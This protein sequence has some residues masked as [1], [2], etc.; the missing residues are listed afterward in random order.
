M[1]IAKKL[2]QLVMMT[3][4]FMLLTGCGAKE[5]TGV[6][7]KETSTAETEVKTEAA[8]EPTTKA[9]VK[10]EYAK[11]ILTD[12]SFES[13]YIG[14][15]FTLPEG[16]IMATEEDMDA[17]IDFGGEVIYKDNASDLLD[18]AKANSVYEMMA[19]SADQTANV[20]V[21]VEK[22]PL[23]NMTVDQYIASVKTQLQ[24]TNLGYVIADE[25]TSFTVGGQEFTSLTTEVENSNVKMTQQYVVRKQD[26]RI[27]ALIFTTAEGVTDIH[28]QLVSAFAPY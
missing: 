7:G 8:T 17:M 10:K 27:I 3:C 4:V 1:K 24:E 11:G 16:M 2:T 14:L 6:A 19:V 18:Y 9:E 21:V 26:N 28:E 23:S 22:L 13:E 5:S 20:I 25:T 15:R 12:S